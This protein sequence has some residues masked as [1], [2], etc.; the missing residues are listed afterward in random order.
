[1][2]TVKTCLSA[3]L[4]AVA[5]SLAVTSCGDSSKV[6]ISNPEGMKEQA[7]KR[8]EKAVP[9]SESAMLGALPSIKEQSRAAKDSLKAMVSPIKDEM[10]ALF[11]ASK[12]KDEAKKIYDEAE[13]MQAN[14]KA[15]EEALKEYYE[16]KIAEAAKPL[17]GR[18]IPVDYDREQFS[19][20]VITVNKVEDNGGVGFDVV[21][22]LARKLP[23]WSVSFEYQD[24]EGM[25]LSKGATYP[26]FKNEPGAQVEFGIYTPMYANFVNMAKIAILNN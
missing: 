15:A 4:V 3:A 19:N 17:I 16:A 22:T 21:M 18:E 24:A 14:V 26:K 23:G 25:E 2:K 13:V 11:L 8:A 20:V 9:I 5:M 10:T 6:D 1:M 12:D 7:I